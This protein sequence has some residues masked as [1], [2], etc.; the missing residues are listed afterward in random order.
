MINLWDVPYW[1]ERLREKQYEFKEEELRCYFALPNVLD[2][3]FSLAN[4]Y[5]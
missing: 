2:G 1:S 5:N 4:R 3:L